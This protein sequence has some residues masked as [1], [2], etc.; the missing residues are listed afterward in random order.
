[1]SHSSLFSL[2][3]VNEHAM[4]EGVSHTVK[5]IRNES[6]IIRWGV[7]VGSGT[8]SFE[9]LKF[10]RPPHPQPH[11]IF[12]STP[13]PPEIGDK[14]VYDPPPPTHT[15]PPI[16]PTNLHT[17]TISPI[18]CL[19]YLNKNLYE[20]KRTFIYFLQFNNSHKLIVCLF[21]CTFFFFFMPVK[22][23]EVE[24]SVKLLIVWGFGAPR[25]HS[26]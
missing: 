1:M 20:T 7:G 18:S 23:S 11:Q 19:S 6:F 12:F 4:R 22:K 8:F 26:I 25:N 2:L 17:H 9:S 24:C 16:P 5:T 13:P 14:K 21:L 15:Y 10:L 3:C